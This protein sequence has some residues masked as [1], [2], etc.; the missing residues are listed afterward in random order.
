MKRLVRRA[1]PL[2]LALLV[3]APA[4]ANHTRQSTLDDRIA[5][6]R[7]RE[8]SLAGQ[9]DGLTGQIRSLEQQ[10]GD[11]SMR[12]GSLE[13]DLALH[14]RRLQ[15]INELARLQDEQLRFLR[16]QY[17]TAVSRLNRRLVQ[18]YENGEPSAIEVVLGAESL[19][20]ALARL[21]YMSSVATQD[22]GIVTQVGAGRVRVRAARVRTQ[23]LQRSVASSTRV[24]AYRTE[25]VRALRDQ[26][27]GRRR[28]LAGARSDSQSALAATKASER[29]WVA[30][31]NALQAA[32]ASVS[33]TITSQSAGS[34]SSSSPPSSS[35]LV[36][37]V[38]GPI[39]SPFGM[40]WG[41]LHP[42]IDIGVGMGT[43][44]R[45][46]A[47]GRVITASYSGGYGNLVVVDH[48]N[49]LA[50]AYAHQSS[51]A[52]TPGQQ[53]SQG[54]VIGYVGSTGFSTGPHLH[55]EVRVNGSPVDPMGYL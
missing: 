25:Q 55:F 51:M 49:G 16:S 40:R 47:S 32:S 17:R 7:A 5:A 45:A 22:K 46:A 24:I 19:N 23:R 48:G 35:G 54:Q 4:A 6:A 11:V 2:A 33:S 36:W 18:I 28:T 31:A 26:L 43:P 12:L 53:V 39:T 41:S 38:S 44:I 3:A 29:D 52:V 37:P 13:N 50:T 15:R 1:A 42:G 34:S 14:R 20:D 9:I 8:A 30:E 10:V 27:D 21:D